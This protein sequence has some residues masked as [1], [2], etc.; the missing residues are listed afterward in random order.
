[1]KK[2]KLGKT[3]LEISLLGFGG[4]HLIEIPA[5]QAAGLLNTY[6]DRGGNYLE[7]AASYGDGE[8][9]KKI[10]EIVKQRRDELILASKTGV[11]DAEGAMEEIDRSLKNLQTDQ[12]DIIFMHGVGDEDDLKEILKPGGSLEAAKKAKEMGK[13]K[14][15]GI[16]GHGQPDVL[17]EALKT[18]EFEVMMTHFNYF[19]NFNFPRLE[20]ELLP[21]V[22]EKNIG[23]LC[24]K[25]LADGFLWQNVE[26]A[27]R[28][29]F[30]LPIDTV[31]TGM[32]NQEMLEMDLKLA[33]EFEPMT[34]VEKE[35]LFKNAEELG[36]YVCRQ[37]KECTVSRQD[38]ENI[39]DVFRMEGYYDRQMYDG[40][41]RN[42]A[43]YA[44][45]DRLRFWFGDQKLAEKRYKQLEIKAADLLKKTAEFKA[46]KY[47]L[48]IKDKLEI[49][50]YKLGES[51]IMQ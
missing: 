34:A 4:F 44:L 33:A 46:C 35:E 42:P 2:R 39:K 7:T 32:N 23:T 48:N 49:V 3:G 36:D 16:T 20:Q 5:D 24:M 30:S 47:G 8:S 28:Y 45:R 40:R 22:K 43:D 9:E 6:L 37:C 26:D 1:M 19:D 21:L 13:V 11:R 41:P 14:H 12:L 15:I 27:F 10:G 31:V 18:G 25:P 29:V 38:G 17:I 50:D 51:E